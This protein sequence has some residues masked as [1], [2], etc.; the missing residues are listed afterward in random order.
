MLIRRFLPGDE[1]ALLRVFQSAIRLVAS[2]DYSRAQIEAWAPA[3]VDPEGWARKMRS[4]APFV[5]EDH[6]VIIGYADLQ[7]DGLIDHFFVAG[8]RQGQGIGGGLMNRILAE[9][10]ETGLTTLTSHVS[11]TAQPFF[12]RFGFR[13]VE[14]KQAVIRGVALD[15]A[16]MRMDLDPDHG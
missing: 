16:L 7:P 14:R 13:I 9:A 10:R 5:A 2:R 8:D 12:R 15:N 1:P 6:G 11:L 3:D 4:I